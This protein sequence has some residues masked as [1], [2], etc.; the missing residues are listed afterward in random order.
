MELEKL[1]LDVQILLNQRKQMHD[2]ISCLKLLL[3]A[4]I[5]EM[6]HLHGEDTLQHLDNTVLSIKDAAPERAQ[7]IASCLREPIER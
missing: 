7:F 6:K 4:V 5:R 2:E 3:T 1:K